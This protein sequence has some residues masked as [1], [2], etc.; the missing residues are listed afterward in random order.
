MPVAGL[1]P[2]VYRHN[3]RPRRLLPMSLTV[4]AVMAWVVA[5]VQLRGNGRRFRSS[6]GA[7]RGRAYARHVNDASRRW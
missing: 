4:I 3:M 7:A 1:S 6:A 5:V 2:S